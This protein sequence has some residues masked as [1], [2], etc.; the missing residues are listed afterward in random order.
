MAR[1]PCARPL[2]EKAGRRGR[3][4]SETAGLREARVRHGVRHGS[5]R[6]LRV[7]QAQELRQ[8][9]NLLRDAY[10]PARLPGIT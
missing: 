4:R 8:L 3:Q 2:R 1:T 6:L 7:P 10:G 5:S 9:P